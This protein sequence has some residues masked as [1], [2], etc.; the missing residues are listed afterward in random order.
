MG[1]VMGENAEDLNDLLNY[2]DPLE[3][4]PSRIGVGKEKILTGMR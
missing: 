4:G 1:G 2:L 3:A